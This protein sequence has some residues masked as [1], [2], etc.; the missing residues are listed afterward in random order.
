MLAAAADVTGVEVLNPFLVILPM[1]S[2]LADIEVQLIL[3]AR[4]H[5]TTTDLDKVGTPHFAIQFVALCLRTTRSVS[6]RSMTA[7]STSTS[8]ISTKNIGQVFDLLFQVHQGR[9]APSPCRK[10]LQEFIGL[11][12]GSECALR[13]GSTRRIRALGVQD[14]HALIAEQQGGSGLESKLGLL[15]HNNTTTKVDDMTQTS[16]EKESRWSLWSSLFGRG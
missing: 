12:S 9:A 10:H 6:S 1:K 8:P 15:P 2:K 13:L 14:V 7:P 3:R 5:G 16:G 11:C 4:G